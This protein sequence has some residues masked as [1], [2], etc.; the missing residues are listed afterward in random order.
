M[1]NIYNMNFRIKVFLGLLL[2]PLLMG[3]DI[4]KNNL[5]KP[6]GVKK[7]SSKLEQIVFKSFNKYNKNIEIKTVKKFIEVCDSFNLTK[8]INTLTA[9]ICL[10][11]GAKHYLNDKVIESSGNAL[12]ICQITPYTAYLYFKNVISKDD[13][14][15]Y[16]LGGDD[17]TH[18]LSIK[19]RIKRR[20]LVKKWLKNETN[21]LVMYGYIMNHCYN[22]YGGLKNSLVAYSKGPSYLNKCLKKDKDLDELDYVYSINKIKN[23]LKTLSD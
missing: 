6:N 13:R 20:K 17:Y 16:E 19:N 14:L 22:K 15:L 9:Q 12:G 23:S 7:E 10:E 4:R 3:N 21:N 5:I 18:I 8:N 2:I 11:S 1:M